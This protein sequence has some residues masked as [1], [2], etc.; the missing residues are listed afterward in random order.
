MALSP[1]SVA[2]GQAFSSLDLTF[3]HLENGI[4]FTG[5]PLLFLVGWGDLWGKGEG[6]ALRANP[7]SQ[8]ILYSHPALRIGSGPTHTSQSQILDF[9]PCLETQEDWPD[10]PNTRNTGPHRSPMPVFFSS[11]SLVLCIPASYPL[12]C[13][14]CGV[15]QDGCIFL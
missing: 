12:P 9:Q 10:R 4:I 14:F 7:P 3:L 11:Y 5:H 1:G 13:S 8:S 6:V 15:P 2:S